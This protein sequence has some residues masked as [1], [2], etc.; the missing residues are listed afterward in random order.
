MD[1][2][3]AKVRFAK[4]PKCLQI[5]TE[6]EGVPVYRCGGCGAI[7]RAKPHACSEQKLSTDSTNSGSQKQSGTAALND[8]STGLQTSGSDISGVIEEG[9][10]IKNVRISNSKSEIC[11]GKV[12]PSG[13]LCWDEDVQRF[14]G[15]FTNEREEMHQVQES[16]LEK[17]NGS[18]NSSDKLE[19]SVT[20]ASEED[21]INVEFQSGACFMKNIRSL[22]AYD[23]SISSTDENGKGDI[24]RNFL[25]LSRRTFRNKKPSNSFGR[26]KEG[27]RFS[28]KYSNERLPSSCNGELS[29]RNVFQAEE[30]DA[31]FLSED[32]HSLGSWMHS[33]SEVNAKQ[34]S[35]L[36]FS[37]EDE[38]DQV[39]I[40]RKVDELRDELSEL[41]N[42]T[43][44][45]Q[46][47]GKANH[48]HGI[49]FHQKH[50]LPH[51]F[52]SSANSN[53]SISIPPGGQCCHKGSCYRCPHN[54]A[55]HLSHATR[56]DRHIGTCSCLHQAQQNL[57]SKDS[58][59]PPML[60]HCRPVSEVH[61]SQS[62]RNASNCSSFQPTSLCLRGGFIGF[63]VVHVPK[64]WNTTSNPNRVRHFGSLQSSIFHRDRT[65]KPTWWILARLKL[66]CIMNGL[67]VKKKRSMF[68]GK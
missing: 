6:F 19:D 52:L 33:E 1:N 21:M 13:L 15:Q 50:T 47:R 40:L 44:K 35:K 48:F 43:V 51:L 5:L 46:F 26:E 65:V 37:K 55:C 58:K 9:D 57:Q 61:P 24:H 56:L 34:E 68:L 29:C 14:S 32:F 3:I 25:R 7:L 38:E 66:L 60:R 4:C 62:A 41:F 10:A 54:I 8:A 17:G 59:P 12:K 39:N 42:K 64:C 18:L 22:N 11:K 36:R 63:D 28:R 16:R 2:K 49:N 30:G 20:T 53:L 67:D 45:N 31:S 27:D 23:G